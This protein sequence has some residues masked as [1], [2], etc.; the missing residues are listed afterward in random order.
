MSAGSPPNEC[1]TT[2]SFLTLQ[3]GVR[4]LPRLSL[5]WPGRSDKAEVSGSSPLRPTLKHLVKSNSLLYF[6]HRDDLGD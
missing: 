1:K 2:Q 6:Q 5:N 3:K 4:R